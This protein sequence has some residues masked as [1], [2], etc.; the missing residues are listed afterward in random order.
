MFRDVVV[1]ARIQ[2]LHP[3]FHPRALRQHQHG[4]ARFFRA[5][6]AENADSVQL[7]QVQVK[8]DEVIFELRGCSP[9][10]FAI[11]QNVH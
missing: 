10:L 7:R 8:N 2:A 5:Q 3:V 9:R 1:R 4:Q 6:V 11:R